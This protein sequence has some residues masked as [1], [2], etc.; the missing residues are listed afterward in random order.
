MFPLVLLACATTP[1]TAPTTAWAPDDG[2]VEGPPAP[3][4][5]TIS[6]SCD[7]AELML[8][9][10]G[11]TPEGRFAVVA[12]PDPAGGTVPGAA[13]DCGG[14]AWDLAPPLRLVELWH[15][16]PI[17]TDIFDLTLGRDLC[18]HAMQAIDLSTCGLSNLVEL[19]D[20][21][22]G[23]GEDPA[24][25]APSELVLSPLPAGH[26][27]AAFFGSYATAYG[28][29]IYAAPDADPAKV[30]H[31]A[32]VM[33]EYLDND[34]DGVV[35]DPA[36]LDSMV[37][38]NAALVMFRTSRDLERSGIFSNP[39]F[40][41]VW[42][43]DLSSQEAK[44]PGEFDIT[45][46]EVLHLINTSGHAHVYPDAF[47]TS[48]ASALTDAMDIARGGRFFAIPPTYPAGAWYHYDD[49]TCDYGCMAVEYL[50]WGLTSKLGAQSAPGRC[51]EIYGEWELCTTAAFEATDTA[52]DAL[53]SDPAYKLP[54]TAPDGI[55]TGL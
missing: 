3:V 49:A 13:G 7:P 50:Y 48:A 37:A 24:V 32:T 33:R 12:S 42:G 21:G 29:P 15:A 14:T 17:G 46:E 4:E 36:L 5:L 41:T 39:W 53:L 31:A 8:R 20:I 9:L 27:G 54:T 23:G 2:A 51:G 6:G 11:L 34:E 19:A 25:P 26:P 43:Q 35:D 40:S 44:I 22:A 52:L 18:G 45:L 1:A 28:I 10:S 47:G 55:Y 30:V 16:T 38:H